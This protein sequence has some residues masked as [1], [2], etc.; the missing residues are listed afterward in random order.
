MRSPSLR[1]GSARPERLADRLVRQADRLP[2]PREPHRARDR[3]RRLRS[4][5]RTAAQARIITAA[6]D[7]FAEHGVNGTSLQMIADAIGVTKAADLPP[8]QD[9]GRDR[10]RRRRGRAREAGSGARR[11]RGRG[12]LAARARELVLAQVIDLAVER[13]RMVSAVQ[14]D[15]VVVRVLA[16]A[17]TVPAAD[18]AACTRADRRRRRR[19][20]GCGRRWS[21]RRSAARSCT[22][23]SMDLDDETLRARI[24]DLTE[25]LLDLPG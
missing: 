8:V 17:R 12:D 19:E 1:A 13:R 18:G 3:E 16:R 2:S 11:G 5:P 6:L 15:P 25:Q 4:V 14:H 24:L 23:S 20:A 7:L 10:P 22:P 21:R 9:E